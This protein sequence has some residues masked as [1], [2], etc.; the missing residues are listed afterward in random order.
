MDSNST[1]TTATARQKVL[2]VLSVL[3]FWILPVSPFL[4]MTAVS[5]TEHSSRWPR[6]L[7]VSGAIL[8]TQYTL[9]LGSWILF[10]YLCLPTLT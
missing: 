9:L 2:A 6:K 5:G 4:A 7:A 1:T 3:C 10:L 8:C